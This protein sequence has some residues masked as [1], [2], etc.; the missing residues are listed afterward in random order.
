MWRNCFVHYW[1]IRIIANNF[2]LFYGIF[3]RAI[4]VNHVPSSLP[5]KLK[6]RW[7]N[8]IIFNSASCLLFHRLT[9]LLGTFSFTFA[10]TF[11]SQFTC[12]SFLHP[13]YHLM[14]SG[15]SLSRQDFAASRF[16][17]TAP[18]PQ[19]MVHYCVP[20]SIHICHLM[21]P[22]SVPFTIMPSEVC[23]N[24]LSLVPGKTLYNFI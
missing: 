14:L 9:Y 8:L 4:T 18:S 2:V 15:Y 19:N 11:L 3:L 23:S 10:A 5:V 22:H 24:R 16:F 1:F 17:Q 20:A 21:S 6:E 13:R 12:D 7:D